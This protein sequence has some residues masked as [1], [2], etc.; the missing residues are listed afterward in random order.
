MPKN[1]TLALTGV[2]KSFKLELE[3]RNP[4]LRFGLNDVAE[5]GLVQ[6]TSRRRWILAELA[7][8]KIRLAF[9]IRSEQNF[10]NL[11][12]PFIRVLSSSSQSTYF[13]VKGCLE[14]CKHWRGVGSFPILG[15]RAGKVLGFRVG[16][17][18]FGLRVGFKK[19]RSSSC[20]TRDSCLF[21]AQWSKGTKLRWD[22]RK[23]KDPIIYQAR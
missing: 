4:T 9:N 15:P 7:L 18:F 21:S 1:S 23:C 12:N 19:F 13:W 8:K 5:S 6:A 3:E 10:L 2:H 22:L 14:R 11:P 16:T 20:R 17:N